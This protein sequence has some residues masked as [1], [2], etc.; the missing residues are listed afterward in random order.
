MAVDGGHLQLQVPRG[1]LPSQQR[2]EQLFGRQTELLGYPGEVQ[3]ELTAMR[4]KD[5]WA[6][7]PYGVAEPGGGGSRH[8]RTQRPV[9]EHQGV[10][11]DATW[12]TA[13]L[14]QPHVQGC[15]LGP[16][17]RSS[18]ELMGVAS[19]CVWACSISAGVNLG[20]MSWVIATQ[21]C[22]CRAHQVSV[23][24][25]CRSRSSR[26]SNAS[27]AGRCRWVASAFSHCRQVRNDARQR[28]W[29][30]GP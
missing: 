10:V 22:P 20:R 19:T 11:G 16:W 8:A 25:V 28:P 4:M 2:V 15:S 14:C 6:E 17:S 23:S 21:A 9:S 12:L 29:L 26:S 18:S 1:R 3:V 27:S 30:N 7:P 5:S 24:M 13:R